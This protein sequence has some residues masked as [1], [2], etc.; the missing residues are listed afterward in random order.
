MLHYSFK[1]QT[2]D[3]NCR[4]QIG[5]EMFRLMEAQFWALIGWGAGMLSPSTISICCLLETLS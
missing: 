3:Y 2:Q 1:S 4:Y 5:I